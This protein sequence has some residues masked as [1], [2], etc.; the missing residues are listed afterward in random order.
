V[1]VLRHYPL[2]A[3]CDL[4]VE[5]AVYLLGIVGLVLPCSSQIRWHPQ[6]ICPG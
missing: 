4:G 2:E 5:E 1:Q 3:G 6:C